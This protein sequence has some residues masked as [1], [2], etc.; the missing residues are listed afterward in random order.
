MSGAVCEIGTN[1][2]WNGHMC[3]LHGKIRAAVVQSTWVV[4]LPCAPAGWAG[5]AGG[6]S[7]SQGSQA[8]SP[9]NGS[10]RSAARERSARSVG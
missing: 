7:G 4:P 3:I 10:G 8:C 2:C 5:P 9:G 6:G 1:P